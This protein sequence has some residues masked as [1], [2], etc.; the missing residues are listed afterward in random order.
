MSEAQSLIQGEAKVHFEQL[1]GKLIVENEILKLENTKIRSQFSDQLREVEQMR[2]TVHEQKLLIEE[3]QK[4]N[5]EQESFI[6][7]LRNNF[8]HMQTQKSKAANAGLNRISQTDSSKCHAQRRRGSLAPGDLKGPDVSDLRTQKKKKH[9]SE[10]LSLY[11]SRPLALGKPSQKPQ[12]PVG[13]AAKH[14]SHK[15]QNPEPDIGSTRQKPKHKAKHK[16]AKSQYS[17]EARHLPA[18]MRPTVGSV[19][20]KA[21]QTFK[22]KRNT[23]NKP[24]KAVKQ[25]AKVK[26][27]KPARKML[28]NFNSMSLTLPLDTSNLH[29]GNSDLVADSLDEPFSKTGLL[30][31]HQILENRHSVGFANTQT[32]YSS[33][34]GLYS[35]R[36]PK[37]DLG[38]RAP[39]NTIYSGLRPKGKGFVGGKKVRFSTRKT[40]ISNSKSDQYM[41]FSFNHN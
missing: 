37:P 34:T 28:A 35:S 18:N 2:R 23:P 19:K 12:N 30:R 3:L 15:Q 13:E 26:P 38:D 5:D 16:K 39:A 20:H 11:N 8:D 17:F 27:K 25:L 36:H 22:K 29:S 24:H 41:N 14:N 6:S 31:A 1:I 9:F 4:Q 10:R 33:V 40:I 32:G 7:T 21:W